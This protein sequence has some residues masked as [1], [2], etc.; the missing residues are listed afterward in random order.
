VAGAVEVEVLVAWLTNR[1]Q[2]L[3]MT[4][5]GYFFRTAG[6]D[7]D[8][9]SEVAARL[10]IMLAVVVVVMKAVLVTT[11]VTNEEWRT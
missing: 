10:S 2:A 6:V 7:K 9:E 11:G 5:A 4:E 8:A 1:E 3:D